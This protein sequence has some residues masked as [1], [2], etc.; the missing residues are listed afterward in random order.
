MKWLLDLFSG[1]IVKQF[2]DPLLQAYQAKLN[3]TNNIDKLEA[4]NTITRIEAA[5]DI[6]IIEAKRPWSATSIGRWLIVLPWG[7]YWSLVYLVSIINPI[8]GTDLVI[9][10]VPQNFNDMAQILIPAIVIADSNALSS[11]I[12]RFKK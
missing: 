10:A 12:G 7:V 1:G 2:T 3:A 9:H 4:E 8:L 6:A 5:R 11:V